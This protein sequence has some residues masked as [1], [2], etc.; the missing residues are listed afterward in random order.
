MLRK[1]FPI[2]R[3]VAQQNTGQRVRFAQR[4]H[5]SAGNTKDNIKLLLVAHEFLLQKAIAALTEPAAQE[6]HLRLRLQDERMRAVARPRRGFQNAD[7]RFSAHAGDG[8]RVAL[9]APDLCKP[10]TE[11]EVN[12]RRHTVLRSRRARVV[13]RQRVDVRRDGAFH[14]SVLQE[15]DRKITMV[16]ADIG[17]P[18]ALRHKICEALQPRLK[19]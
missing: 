14:S 4:A 9:F 11:A 7:D 3:I 13:K 6:I 1:I 15:P 5:L 16:G 17:K 19:L 10:R 2:Q 12:A 18:R 8:N